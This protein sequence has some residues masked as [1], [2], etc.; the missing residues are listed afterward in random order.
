MKTNNQEITHGVEAEL[1][2]AERNYWVE[3][4]EALDRLENGT[5]KPGDFKKVI[6]EGYFKDRAIDG[7]SML[8]TDYTRQT[9]TRGN[10]L[11]TLV[12][13][14]L[15]QDHFGVIKNLGSIAEDDELAL[16]GPEAE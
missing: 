14:S 4:K 5:P 13:I 10:I 12:A 9:G 11:E 15:L 2:T 3:Q 7:V 16:N 1:E 8:A 6:L